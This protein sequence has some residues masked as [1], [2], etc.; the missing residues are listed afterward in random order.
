MRQRMRL[1]DADALLKRI[2]EEREYLLMRGQKGAEHILVHNFRDLI[3]DAPTAVSDEA[4]V[5]DFTNITEEQK[6]QL[7]NLLSKTRL[8]VIDEDVIWKN[9]YDACLNDKSIR[10]RPTGEWIL[11]FS[12][13]KCC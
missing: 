10:E 2:D 1:I 13:K 6:Q 11:C 12:S 3:E 5:L 9:G 4:I 7:V 8:K